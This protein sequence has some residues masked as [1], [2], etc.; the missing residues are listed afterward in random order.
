MSSNAFLV[1]HET[2]QIWLLEK[3]GTNESKT[4]FVDL[5]K[6]VFSERGPNGLLSIA[7]HPHFRQNHKYYL[8]HQILEDGKIVS[9]VVERKVSRGFS[10]ATRARPRG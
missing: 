4:L 1:V 2:G 3:N 10:H 6:E 7:F 5:S 9:T 8:N